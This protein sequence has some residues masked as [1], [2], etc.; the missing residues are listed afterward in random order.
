VAHLQTINRA[1]GNVNLH[2][3]AQAQQ[4]A[5]NHAA[6]AK[7]HADAFE[8]SI[9]NDSPEERKANFA[10]VIEVL[11]NA[12]YDVRSVVQLASQPNDLGRMLSSFETQSMLYAAAKNLRAQRA[13]GDLRAQLAKLKALPPVTSMGP[14]TRG[15][16]PAP[17]S[18]NGPS[19][20]KL[21]HTLANS[22]GDAALKAA[23]QLL[24]ARRSGG[25]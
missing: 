19:T 7:Q 15:S 9:A 17:S 5:T 18:Y 20:Q 16:A 1:V 24:I 6:F 8:R 21:A 3:Q 13:N 22:R 14:G 12:G 23:T 10:A 25:R 11:K 4:A 2:K